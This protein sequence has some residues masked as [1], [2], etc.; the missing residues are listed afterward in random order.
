MEKKR[1]RVSNSLLR[2]NIQYK[3]KKKCLALTP[4]EVENARKE[5]IHVR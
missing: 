2:Y 5:T 4:W 1:K 3:K